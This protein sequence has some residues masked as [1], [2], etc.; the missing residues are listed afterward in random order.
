MLGKSDFAH[1]H[2]TNLASPIYDSPILLTKP[3]NPNTILQKPLNLGNRNNPSPIVKGKST[4]LPDP[5]KVSQTKK[6]LHQSSLRRPGTTELST[7][8]TSKTCDESGHTLVLFTESPTLKATYH[9]QPHYD[10]KWQID[11]RAQIWCYGN[12]KVAWLAGRLKQKNAKH[13]DRHLIPLSDHR[14]VLRIDLKNGAGHM[15]LAAIVYKG[16]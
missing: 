9:M 1:W 10:M 5:P 13:K 14:P 8:R 4:T 2:R 3:L 7:K 16:L 6:K 11:F 12:L 15:S